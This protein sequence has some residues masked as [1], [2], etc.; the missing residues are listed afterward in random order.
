MDHFKQIWNVGYWEVWQ[1][2]VAKCHRIQQSR[3]I[4]TK[5]HG[6]QMTEGYLSQEYLNHIQNLNQ[7]PE[8]S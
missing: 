6:T 3:P 4:S 7:Y 5:I 1:R 8:S 2:T